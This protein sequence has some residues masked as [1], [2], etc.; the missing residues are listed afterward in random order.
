MRLQDPAVPVE[1]RLE[2][3]DVAPAILSVAREAGS[4]LIVMAGSERRWPWCLRTGGVGEEV[5]RKAPCAVLR[6]NSQ[7]PGTEGGDF[8]E[9]REGA[10]RV[11]LHPTDF[12]RPARH[13]LEAARSLARESDSE[14]IVLHVA[15]AAVLNRRIGPRDEIEAAL[16][17]IT[18]EAPDIRARGVLLADDP[19]AGILRAA[20]EARCDLVVMG[21]RDRGGLGRMFARGVSAE[22]RR[23]SP[24]PVATVNAP[25]GPAAIRRRPPLVRAAT[26]SDV[27]R[28]RPEGRRVKGART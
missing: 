28:R 3:G 2:E 7:L 26:V 4:E 16:R 10:L 12:S 6:L 8:G 15:P 5:E 25:T 27:V 19:A 13:A 9:G 22:V 21:T 23:H 20:R 1:H 11:I 17:R 24:C 14:L 18:A